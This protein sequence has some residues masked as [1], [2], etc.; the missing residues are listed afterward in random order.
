[1][2]DLKAMRPTR[3]ELATFGLK[4][5]RA[6]A[7]G[8]GGAEGSDDVTY[9]GLTPR[10]RQL[11][12]QSHQRSPELKQPFFGAAD[13]FRKVAWEDPILAIE[14]IRSVQ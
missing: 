5:R 13:L 7:G 10:F 1:L 8:K 12:R 3:F 11:R 6:L 9:T 14:H 2:E 4:G